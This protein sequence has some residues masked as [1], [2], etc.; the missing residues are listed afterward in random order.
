MEPYL[1]KNIIYRPK[2][3]FGLPIRKWIKNELNDFVN[4]TLSEKVLRN[5][6]LF[7]PS[8]VKSLIKANAEGSVDGSYTILSIICIELWCQKFLEC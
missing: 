3:G 2:T 4:D 5:R 1:P 8:A 7:D 6:G